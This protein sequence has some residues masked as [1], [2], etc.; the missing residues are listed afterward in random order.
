MDISREVISIPAITLQML[1]GVGSIESASFR[2][3]RV[4]R[5]W[6]CG[7]IAQL[8]FDASESVEWTPCGLH[9]PEKSASLNR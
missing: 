7:C 8:R 2:R 6:P 1:L 3:S 5:F 4:E 9:A